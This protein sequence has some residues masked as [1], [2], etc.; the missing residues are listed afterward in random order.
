MIIKEQ[1]MK[2]GMTSNEA[3]IYFTL[4]KTG[5]TSG[6]KIAQELK[7]IASTVYYVLEGLEERGYVTRFINNNK[8]HFSAKCPYVIAA[9]E[10][11]KI[12]AFE[13]VLPSVSAYMW[14]DDRPHVSQ[15]EGI[16][17]LLI[18]R[19]RFHETARNK[20]MCIL[21][22]E[23][24][25]G[26]AHKS[27]HAIRKVLREIHNHHQRVRII[28]PS[29]CVTHM[30]SHCYEVLVNFSEK[31]DWGIR[32]IPSSKYLPRQS[33]MVAGEVVRIVTR[34]PK[35]VLL[36][37]DDPYAHSKRQLFNLVWDYAGTTSELVK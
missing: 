2:L 16:E 6:Y 21:W 34:S 31:Y 8:H 29:D 33:I 13:E 27:T 18:S 3:D 20:D 25:E 5:P 35:Y 37:Q 28:L 9:E 4:L 15:Y 23:C 17:G 14:Q 7:A 11:S 30:S 10:R 36:I 22:T 12:D 1:F 32:T 26:M 24:L 19:K